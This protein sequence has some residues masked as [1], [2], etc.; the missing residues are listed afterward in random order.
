MGFFYVHDTAAAC[1]LFLALSKAWQ[2][3]F[4]FIRLP[5]TLAKNG[6]LI[7]FPKVFLRVTKNTERDLYFVYKFA[8]DTLMCPGLE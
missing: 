6:R 5:I 4:Y 3:C 8:S 2:S 7:L 1:R